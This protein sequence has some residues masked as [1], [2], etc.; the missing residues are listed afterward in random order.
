MGM[1]CR[2]RCF[3][4]KLFEQLVAANSSESVLGTRLSI[5]LPVDRKGLW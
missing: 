5:G 4:A 1:Q 2:Q 3:F